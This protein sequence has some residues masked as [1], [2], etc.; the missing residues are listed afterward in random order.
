MVV[1]AIRE[2]VKYLPSSTY[3]EHVHAG[4]AHGALPGHV[5]GAAALVTA[6]DYGEVGAVLPEWA[7]DLLDDR[8][9]T[10]LALRDRELGYV[11]VRLDPPRDAARESLGQASGGLFVSCTVCVWRVNL[12]LE[13]VRVAL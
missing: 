13:A 2:C 3:L 1:T 12:M 9:E 4:E 6:A 5:V 7:A 8:L 10:E 11:D